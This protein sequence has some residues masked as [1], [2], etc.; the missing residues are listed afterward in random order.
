ML[1][2]ETAARVFGV[3]ASALFLSFVLRTVNA[4]IASDLSADLLL[5]NAQL[6]SLSGAYFLGFVLM[7][8]PLGVLLDRKGARRTQAWLL[9]VGAAGCFGFGV[10]SAYSS[11]WICRALM[12][13]GTAAA[14]MSALKAFRFWYSADRQQQLAAWI[15]VAGT[16]GALFA[17]VPVRFAVD[18]IG[19]RGVFGVFG[20]LLVLVSVALLLMVP[21]DE[22]KAS[23]ARAVALDSSE[24]RKSSVRVYRSIFSDPYF[25]RFGVVAILSHGG[26]G[27]MQALWAGPWLREVQGLGADTAAQALLYFNLSML[28]GYVVQSWAIR[29]TPLR[30][31]PMPKIVAAAALLAM[32]IEVGIAT[33]S[34]PHAWLLWLPLAVTMTFFTLVLTHISLSFPPE[35]T[36]RAYVAFNVLIFSGNWFV[37]LAFGVV[38]DLLVG[39]FGF[40]TPQAFRGAMLLWVAAQLVGLALLVTSRA[41]PSF[42]P[43]AARP[44]TP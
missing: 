8:L 30:R 36:G 3:F 26:I 11:L 2:R 43:A 37:Q 20:V 14:L 24:S 33:W 5:S 31:M 13:I 6:G 4:S 28:V 25:R 22:D 23:A 38:V 15:L 42:A 41:K 21:R 34:A 9:L 29:S 32:A 19:W 40:T 17:T 1:D 7:Q 39:R 44:R 35:F 12:G 27:A 10:V 16:G 18:Q